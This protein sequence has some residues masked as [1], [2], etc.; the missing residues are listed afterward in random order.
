MGIVIECRGD[1]MSSDECLAQRLSSE[2]YMNA[3]VL[4]CGLDR[5]NW[6]QVNIVITVY[7]LS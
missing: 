4:G 3:G 7:Y 6:N 2:F 1:L 5:L